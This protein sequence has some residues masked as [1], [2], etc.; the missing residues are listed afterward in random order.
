MRYPP[1][2]PNEALEFDE[3][4]QVD[5]SAM[6]RKE[7]QGL[8]AITEEQDKNGPADQEWYRGMLTRLRTAMMTPEQPMAPPPPHMPGTS[9]NANAI[10]EQ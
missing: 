9:G 8:V 2:Y 6:W 4:G 5:W 10:S 3:H 1:L 7:L